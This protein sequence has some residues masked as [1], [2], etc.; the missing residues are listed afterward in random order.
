MSTG[1]FSESAGNPAQPPPLGADDAAGG[2]DLAVAAQAYS[3]GNGAGDRRMRP[4]EK[5][6]ERLVRWADP[7]KTV[8]IAQEILD[9]PDDFPDGEDL[10]GRIG[11][12]VV[13]EY[14]IDV[15][16]RSEW[17]DRSKKA[18]ALAMQIAKTKT[19]PWEGASNIIYP[20]IASAAIQFAA[21]AYPALVPG[22]DIVK[23]D[24]VGRDDGFPELD[25]Q[26]QKPVQG[27]DGKVVWKIKP[28]AKRERSDRIAQHMS[29][30]LTTEQTEWQEETDRLTLILP[31]VGCAFRKTYYDVNL[32][33]NV[34][35]LVRAE[36]LVINYRAKSME[37]APRI[38]EIMKLYPY[39]I[40]E[41]E[42]AGTFLHYEYGLAEGAM[43]GDEDAPH[44]FLE[45]HRRWDIDGDGYPEPYI[46]TVHERTAKVVRIVS[47]WD[48]DGVLFAGAVHEVRR[49]EP[50]DYY[51]KYDFFP[52]PDGGIYGVG[53][54]ELLNPINEGIN[55]TL[56][57]L[58]D[59][60][61]L[62]NTGGGFIGK[63]LSMQAGSLKFKLGEWKAV[64]AL[65][66]TVRDSIVP[67]S[68]PGPSDTLFK[69]LGF[70]VETGK[71]LSANAE[72][73]TG[74]QTQSN[75]P[76]TTTMALIEQGLNVYK[77]I[78]KR[79][80][81]SLTSE[82]KKQ[83]RL[84][85]L[86]LDKQADF[87]R[88]NEWLSIAQT[89]YTEHTGVL[90][91]SDPSM[92]SDMQQLARAQFLGG[93]MNDFWVDNTEVRRRMFQAAHIQDIDKLLHDDPMKNPMMILRMR[94]MG[95]KEIAA[96]AMALYHMSRGVQALALADKAVGDMHMSWIDQHFKMLQDEMDRVNSFNM[97]PQPGEPPKPEPMLQEP[98]L[99]PEG[100]PPG[101]GI[102]GGGMGR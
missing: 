59:A 62:Q 53:F 17:L 39:E 77:S 25:P 31:I 79:V 13:R 50:V 87:R 27:P 36:D 100:D 5:L 52:N 93:F 29:W 85:R 51:T 88:G 38:T 70:L 55:T 8:N 47:R 80:Y 1:G 83:Y 26:T 22:E 76:A 84:N 41:E 15:Q 86:Y 96:K 71:E 18:M 74:Q 11:Q 72:V 43:E 30:Q 98:P 3:N 7:T 66:S 49:I 40:I 95:V 58:F 102:Y 63:G 67:F 14:E 65:G 91:V 64:N 81:L 45:Q 34:G 35:C 12:K 20:L 97:P 28:G 37:T 75:V 46:V 42:K 68:H 60:G 56:N 69:L 16:S 90:P 73:L 89:D 4:D 48:A 24:T 23:G 19:T 44:Q 10:L 54:G 101:V 82:L 57:Q 32:Q 2:T 94:E 61:T 78:Y 21:R 92:V 33:R 9:N 99:P 6:T